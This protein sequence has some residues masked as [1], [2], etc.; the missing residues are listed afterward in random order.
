MAL[1]TGDVYF[2]LNTSTTFV[3]SVARGLNPS[4]RSYIGSQMQVLAAELGLTVQ[5]QAAV[6]PGT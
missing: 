6:E 3:F 5:S 2:L 1:G 4:A